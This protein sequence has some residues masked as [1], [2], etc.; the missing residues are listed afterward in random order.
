MTPSGHKAFLVQNTSDVELLLMHNRTFAAEYDIQSTNSARQFA[1]N[2][3]GSDTPSL[4]ASASR[5][6]PRP[7]LSVSRSPTPRVASPLTPKCKNLV[8]GCFLRCFPKGFSVL[9]SGSSYFKNTKW[10]GLGRQKLVH[11]DFSYL[12]RNNWGNVDPVTLPMVHCVSYMPRNSYRN[13]ANT[14]PRRWAFFRS[15]IAVLETITTF[16]SPRPLF[17]T[18]TCISFCDF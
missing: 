10:S 7:R 1:N 13:R 17:S 14:S 4:P 8:L 9:I 6:S 2:H 16:A 3:I 5:S 18:L 15:S 11:G 12:G